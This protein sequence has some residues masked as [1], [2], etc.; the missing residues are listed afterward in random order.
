[1]PSLLAA[2]IEGL[3]RQAQDFKRQLINSFSSSHSSLI[4]GIP[5]NA[6]DMVARWLEIFRSRERIPHAEN[7][8]WTR[9]PQVSPKIVPREL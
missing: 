2:K 5:A 8:R 3:G 7:I 1:M 9:K 4:T 6:V